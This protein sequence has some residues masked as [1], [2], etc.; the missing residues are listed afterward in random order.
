MIKKHYQHFNANLTFNSKRCTLRLCRAAFYLSLLLLSACASSPSDEEL[1]AQA[2]Q[3]TQQN[4]LQQQK[5]VAEKIQRLNLAALEDIENSRLK[6]PT[7]N[8]A[9]EKVIQIETLDPSTPEIANL[10]DQIAQQYAH[11]IKIALN[12]ENLSKAQ[13]YLSNARSIAKN[14]TSIQQAETWISKYQQE[15]KRRQSEQQKRLIIANLQKQKR[16]EIERKQQR[17]QKIPKKHQTPLIQSE[18]NARSKE[19]GFQLDKISTAI[20][21]NNQPVTIRA[22]SQRD[23]RWLAALLKTSLYVVDSNYEPVIS[24]E[25]NNTS[26]P[27]I[28]YLI[29][30]P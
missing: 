19:V 9:L 10:R 22:Q 7:G 24:H 18:I 30:Q 27:A 8:N 6:H 26:S 25:I 29:R 3:L 2:I 16:L 11:L 1:S 21:E 23:F 4:E 20:I 28:Y 17:L 14:S 12:Q 13:L 5:M 15:I